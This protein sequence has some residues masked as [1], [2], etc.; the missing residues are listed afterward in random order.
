MRPAD[1]VKGL[2][3]RRLAV[4]AGAGISIGSPSN[5]LPAIQFT[6]NVLTRL[7][8]PDAP[9]NCLTQLTSRPAGPSRPGEK[10]RFESLMTALVSSGTDPELRVLQCLDNTTSPNE[11]HAILASLILEGAVVMTV[12][13]DTLIE[14]AYSYIAPAVAPPLQV[15]LYDDDF[16]DDGSWCDPTPRLWKLHGSMRVG[17]K[18]T[19]ASIQATLPAVLARSMS[20]RK[21][22]FLADVLADRDL[23]V[24]GYSGGDD[25]DIVPLLEDTVSRHR[26]VWIDHKGIG[27]V[28]PVPDSRK[29]RLHSDVL[30]RERIR[31][32][33]AADM[34]E[35]RPPSAIQ[36]VEADTRLVLQAMMPSVDTEWVQQLPINRFGIT[37]PA[38]VKSYFDRWEKTLEGSPRSR[39]R[40]V[41]SLIEPRAHRPDVASTLRWVR[42][43]L[44]EPRS[45]K[46]MDPQERLD[47]IVRRFHTESVG[48]LKPLS[49][50]ITKMLRRELRHR[51]FP[52]LHNEQRCVAARVLAEMTWEI[53]GPKKGARRFEEA[54]ASARQ[55]GT[56]ADELT[57][58]LSWLS[59]D[60]YTFDHDLYPDPS[61]DGEPRPTSREARAFTN[62]TFSDVQLRR[63]HWLALESGLLTDVWRMALF[64]QQDV[65]DDNPA[66]LS[67]SCRAMLRLQRYFVD[68]GDVDGEART[69]LILGR[70]YLMGAEQHGDTAIYDAAEE[71]VRAVEL[72][73][74][75]RKPD[76][77][78]M[79]KYFLEHAREALPDQD[80]LDR[81]VPVIHDS[82][83]TS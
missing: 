56:P 58:L 79:A 80:F 48:C 20:R 11:N 3:P 6:E 50:R 53:S 66:T 61:G 41:E 44:E 18:T 10:L 57:T 76:L 38:E 1:L 14:S 4:L 69:T 52:R 30:G 67:K 33:R 39:Y 40:L 68:L 17:E 21:R 8:P 54:V 46:S 49:R 15:A 77:T 45:S 9:Q 81:M 65:L 37:Y 2:S 32:D 51:V 29:M 82:L 22:N 83:W 12:N 24:V 59:R 16:P 42:H 60:R 75:A 73:E 63:V 74:Y 23:L 70:L 43:R 34:S 7:T 47:W 55:S 62:G 71:L 28:T 35:I 26:L 64:S 13:F 19:R 72:S 31:Y 78:N 5:L 36:I 25:F 27:G